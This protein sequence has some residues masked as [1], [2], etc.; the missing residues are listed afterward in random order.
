[1]T[2]RLEKLDAI[3]YG[4][5]ITVEATVSAEFINLRTGSVEWTGHVTHISKVDQHDVYSV[6]SQMSSPLMPAWT[7][8]S[9]PSR[10]Q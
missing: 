10:N 1:M 9:R 2:G 8:S 7:N 3:D 4:D 6:V 5:G